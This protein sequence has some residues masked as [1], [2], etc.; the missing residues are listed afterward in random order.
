MMRRAKLS[1]D[2]LVHRLIP[3]R[4]LDETGLELY[5]RLAASRGTEERQR[6]ASDLLDR[7]CDLGY[8]KL[9]NRDVVGG[10]VR[11]TYRNLVSLDTLT[12]STP[13][14]VAAQPPRDA[15]TADTEDHADRVGDEGGRTTEANSTPRTPTT[16]VDEGAIPLSIL[17]TITASSRRVDLAGPLGYLHE[18]LDETLH[19]DHVKLRLSDNLMASQANSLVDIEDI[20]A[21]SDDETVCPPALRERVE[22]DATALHAGNI[23]SDDRFIGHG[24]EAPR[25]SI[26]VAPL[27]AEAYVYGTL[28]VWS[29]RSEAF[30]RGDVATV[31]FVAEFAGGLI[32]RRLEIEEL[33]SV[34]QTTQIHNRRYFDEQLIRELERSKRTGHPMSLLMIDLDDFKQV[35]DSYGHAAGDSVLRQVARL[36]LENARAVDIVARYGGEEFAVILPRVTRESALT[37]AE[38]MRSSVAAH[39][40]I[41]GIAPEP[42]RGLTISVGGAL[43]PLDANTKSELM[44]RAD[45]IGLYEAKRGGKNRVVF[46]EDTLKT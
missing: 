39:E 11:S 31:A 33:I 26:I 44:D 4:Y 38:R 2:E 41:T 19:G 5:R 40:F 42:L 37:V 46:W 27:K 45:R 34:D 6:A 1:Y 22:R 17:E 43:Y 13:A 29:R 36:L 3:V 12:L 32:R 20:I 23:A 8:M 24:T 15:N 14:A 28:E 35:N 9:V 10:V 30:T 25:G 16:P 21:T 7:L 18:F